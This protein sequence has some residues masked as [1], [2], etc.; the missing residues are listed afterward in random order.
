MMGRL[1]A[2]VPRRTLIIGSAMILVAG[3][4]LWS[5]TTHPR[6]QAM[7]QAAK[8]PFAPIPAHENAIVGGLRQN[9]EEAIQHA[10]AIADL[11][12][13]AEQA[14]VTI[15]RL[16]TELQQAQTQLAL[17]QTAAPSGL[18]EAQTRQ[19]IAEQLQ[20]V[21]AAAQPPSAP[22]PPE[23]KTQRLEGLPKSTAQAPVPDSPPEPE[24]H[25]IRIPDRSTAKAVT[26]SGSVAQASGEPRPLSVQIEADIEGPNGVRLPL[27]GCRVA[28]TLVVEAI[29]ARAL[30]RI[31]GLSCALRLPDGRVRPVE[32]AA[33]GWLTGADNMNGSFADLF[34][35]EADIYRRFGQA[36][37]PVA[38]VSLLKETRQVVHQVSPL[39]GVATTVGNDVAQEIAR[40]IA[41]FYID[42]AREYFDPVAWVG[43]NQRV[44]VHFDGGVTLPIEAH[45]LEGHH[46]ATRPDFSRYQ[47]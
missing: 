32:V 36:A 37:I 28:A 26:L 25:W 30:T 21:R 24:R 43:D 13:Q 7:W 12:A 23:P 46:V 14:Q 5:S 22:P 4:W 42:K 19:L 35:N 9:R 39:T 18:S 17:R 34:D 41:T 8:D 44:Y 27:S 20:Y 2:R 31:Q 38:L 47:R 1:L 11:K 29:P 16:Q 10:R 3:Y 15:E 45:E 6:M 33:N 40:E